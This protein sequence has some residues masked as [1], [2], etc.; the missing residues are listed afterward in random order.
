MAAGERAARRMFRLTILRRQTPRALLA[1]WAIVTAFSVLNW[2]TGV[3]TDLD[4]TL[5]VPVSLLLLASAWASTRAWLPDRAL[6]W[7]VA[8]VSMVTLVVFEIQAA[9]AGTG[10]G[11][12]YVVVGLALYPSLVMAW[13]P[14][15]VTAAPIVAGAAWAAAALDP[16][17]LFDWLAVTAAGLATGLLLLQLRLSSID[18]LGQATEQL[19]LAATHDELTGVLNRHGIEEQVPTLLGLAERHR[20]GVFAMFVDVD[21]LKRANDQHGHDFGDTVLRTVAA[22]LAGRMRAGDLVGR[23]GGD[24]FI[25]VGLGRPDEPDALA[26]RVRQH[27]A[28][29]GLD[30]SRWDGRISVGSASWS[31]EETAARRDGGFPGLLAAADADMYARRR[32]RRG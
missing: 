30:L 20:D 17:P 14:V 8:A 13:V 29:S 16:D 25:V 9:Y 26:A 19:R 1:A 28:T 7:L 12:A 22:G 15:L 5:N 6:P 31:S 23:W 4:R 2:L 18:D 27:V 3:S 11:Y 10:S 32:V 21:G 24:E